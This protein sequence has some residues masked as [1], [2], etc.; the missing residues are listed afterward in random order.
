MLCLESAAADVGDLLA[1]GAEE[2]HHRPQASADLFD[3][4]R[5]GRPRAAR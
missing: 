5:G 3:L 4:V 2:R 1:A